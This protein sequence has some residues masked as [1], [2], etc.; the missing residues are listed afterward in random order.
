MT[1]K[2]KGCTPITAKLQKT[3]KG[4]MIQEPLLN[5]GAPVKMKPGRDISLNTKSPAYMTD[6]PGDK[7]K[8]K[9]SKAKVGEIPGYEEIKE[10]FKGKYTV[11][12]KKGKINE[13]SLY[14]KSGRSI[15]YKPGKKVKDNSITVKE[16]VQMELNKKNK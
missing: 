15:T 16:A 7:K 11:V 3:T 1:Y 2:Q 10:R 13:Y 12:P 9:T 5:M 14:N 4:G 8:P 6:D